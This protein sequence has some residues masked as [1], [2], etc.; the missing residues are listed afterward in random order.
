MLLVFFLP[1]I[2]F[3]QVNDNFNDNDFTAGTLWSGDDVEWTAT[4]GQL[5]TNGPAVTP[6]TTHLSTA[7]T[8]ASNCQWEFFANPKCSTSSGN[9]MDV[10]LTSDSVNLEGLGS[11]YFVRVGN[12]AD[13]VSLYKKIAGVSTMIIDGTDG[14]VGSSSNNPMKV[15][16]ICDASGNFSLYH[17]NTGTGTNYVLQGTVNDVTLTMS[18]F[19]GV[20][21]KYSA[22]N[23][24]KYFFD[25]VYVGPIIIDN[26][27]PTIL[28]ASVTDA[29]RVDLHFSEAVDSATSSNH[30]N[31]T[32][33]NSIG[34]P[35]SATRDASNFSLIHLK[36]LIPLQSATNYTLTC[37][38]VQDIAGN[39]TPG[40][41][42]QFSFYQPQQYDVLINEIMAN[43]SPV[44]ALP[45]AEYLELFNRS[46][47]PININNWT[48]SDATST[49]T[50]PSC[51]IQPDSFLI[52]C[53]ASNFSLLSPFGNTLALSSMPT[54]NDDGDSLKLRNENGKLINAVNYSSSWY[55]DALKDAGGWSL[56]RIDPANP[57]AGSTNWKA[58]LNLSGGT[59]GKINS[60][61]AN[62][63]DATPPQ[64]VRATITDNQTIKLFFSESLDSAIA[65]LIGNYS[66]TPSLGTI[67]SASPQND[68][69][70]VVISF[71]QTI[72]QGTIY[73]ITC[74]NL[75]DCTGNVI[76]DDN[77]TQF[78]VPENADSNDVII[79]E[80][81]YN[82]ITGG[83]DFVELFNRSNKILDLK[84]L[85]IASRN[86][87]GAVI[88]PSQCSDG[89]LLMPGEYVAI[90]ENADWVKANY[91]T[92]NP[93]NILTVSSIPSFNDDKGTVVITTINGNILDE[94][95]Y[96]DKWQFALL[97]NHEGVTLERISPDAVTQDS[98]NWH[99]AAST[100]GFGT[101]AY[102][103]SQYKNPQ[104]DNNITV[105]PLV[106]SPDQDGFND[107]VSVLYNFDKPGY[108]VTISVFNER[109]LLIR[110]LVQN[111]LLEQ[112]GFFNWDGITDDKLRAQVG[113]YIIFF[114]YF[115]LTGTVHHEKKICVL[116]GKQN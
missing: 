109:G 103:N 5:Q 57:C 6:T 41:N 115:D 44:V 116:A 81:L 114:E 14:T 15:K 80:I 4:T 18:A 9:Y 92:P 106:F 25:D 13:E 27:P 28:S 21:V 37:I 83:S 40:T 69:S 52:L 53:S 98:L 79:N 12:T 105:D 34:Q 3:A 100:V 11:G 76:A 46:A 61:H 84:Q 65:S 64:L 51:T 88:S 68:F 91:M 33:N 96:S 39:G 87:T 77:F 7:S 110:S 42:A 90:T 48:I 59:P 58:S 38:G 82:P 101:P 112:K 85:Y 8:L 94:L 95:H 26:T 36:L 55:N 54:L 35:D 22:S 32:I 62:N 104:G 29:L 56:E 74:N 23:N 19:F 31:Y 17:D 67:N 50:I 63:P 60:V 45:D 24:T 1:K 86:D 20:L 43:P 30:L 108:V 70:I 66:V 49:Y 10:Y 99:S 75:S 97:N 2:L 102:Q 16:V 89:F 78:A 72:Q 93:Q 111:A 107:V 73:T 71:S 113:A 47:F